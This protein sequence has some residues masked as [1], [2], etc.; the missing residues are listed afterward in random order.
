MVINPLLPPDKPAAHV[1]PR[2]TQLAALCWRMGETGREVLLVTSS[3]GRWILPKGWPMPHRPPHRA[4]RIEAWEEAGVA[5]GKVG[6]KPVGDYIS[7]KR[8]ESGDD[9]PV[10]H[11][12]YAIRVRELVDDFPEAGRRERIWVPVEEAAKMVDE[13]GLRDLLLNFR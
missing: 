7:I 6:R 4:A 11:K 3:S 10:L 1:L 2:R 13:E 5:K 9:V 8:T 12:V